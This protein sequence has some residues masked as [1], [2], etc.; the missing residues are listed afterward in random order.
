MK[1]TAPLKTALTGLLLT[2][3]ATTLQAAELKRTFTQPYQQDIGY[4]QVVRDGNMLYLSGVGSG[5][6]TVEEQMLNAY[7]VI[8]MVL[9]EQG[10]GLSDI[11]QERISTTD[12]DALKAAIPARKALFGEGQYPASSWYQIDRLF[13]PDMMIEIEVIARVPEAK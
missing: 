4:A 2:C 10:A 12:M 5:G 1:K 8:G 11:L 7:K 6:K 13:M 9:N 3:L